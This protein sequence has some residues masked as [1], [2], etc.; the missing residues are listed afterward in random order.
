MDIITRLSTIKQPAST[1]SLLLPFVDEDSW[2]DRSLATEP[3]KPRPNARASVF[4]RNE[5][6][7]QHCALVDHS[8]FV[9]A[10]IIY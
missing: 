8:S 2:L 9:N 7:R 5:T 6:W 1:H 3:S 10:E 4:S